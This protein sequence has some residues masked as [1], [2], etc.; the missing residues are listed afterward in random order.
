MRGGKRVSGI[1]CS[2]GGDGSLSSDGN[3]G[4]LANIIT[5]WCKC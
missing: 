1:S 4:G 3:N 2:G 5:H